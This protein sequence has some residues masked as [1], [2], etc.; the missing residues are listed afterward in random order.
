MPCDQCKRK[1]IPIACNY[2]TGNF[3]TRCIHLDVH[4]CE[5]IQKKKDKDMQNLKKSLPTVIKSKVERF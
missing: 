3:C 2:C 5:G 4:A 1:G